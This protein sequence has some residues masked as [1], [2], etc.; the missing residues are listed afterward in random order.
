MPT[1]PL[2]DRSAA[3]G[4]YRGVTA[5]GGYECWAFDAEDPATDTQLSIVFAAGSPQDLGYL[6][7]HA[8]YKRRPT[9]TLPP[10]P[11]DY[12]G[13][14]VRVYRAEVPV[15]VSYTPAKLTAGDSLLWGANRLTFD[16]AMFRLHVESTGMTLDLDF[17]RDTVPL[18]S[19]SLLKCLR[20]THHEWTLISP[21]ST[22]A[23]SMELAGTK[24]S[25]AG[26]GSHEYAF[27]TSPL[28]H[29]VTRL[30]RGR[31]FTADEAVVF[32]VAQPSVA[33]AG[34]ESVICVRSGGAIELDTATIARPFADRIT[35]G[36]QLTLSS[37]RI[38]DHQLRGQRIVYDGQFRGKKATAHCDTF[39]PQAPRTPMKASVID[40]LISPD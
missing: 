4:T 40:W 37:P 25:F 1:I 20:K 35:F 34:Q 14:L 12:A 19:Q 22:V 24:V 10:L 30:L 28:C 36:D 18:P 31:I 13:V 6:R 38:I 26:V 7:H 11:R 16:A 39:Y 15:H 8:H 17:S 29:G 23:G 27:G 5:P 21:R 9:T 3:P 33:K 2:Y 32:Q